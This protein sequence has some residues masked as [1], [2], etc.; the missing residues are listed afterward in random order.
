MPLSH[1]DVP[2]KIGGAQ[3]IYDA[4]IAA[5]MTDRVFLIIIT[6]RPDESGALPVIEKMV[7]EGPDRREE[8]NKRKWVDYLVKPDTAS[9]RE[10]DYLPPESL[11]AFWICDLIA[12]IPER[13]SLKKQFRWTINEIGAVHPTML[14]TIVDARRVAKRVRERQ[15]V[16][17]NG[18]EGTEKA[19]IAREIHAFSGRRH[20]ESVPCTTNTLTPDSIAVQ[21][22]GAVGG[23]KNAPITDRGLF[24]RN[25]KGT[26][27]FDEFGFD[28]DITAELSKHLQ[29]FLKTFRYRPQGSTA[30]RHYKFEGPEV[31]DFLKSLV[32]HIRRPLLVVWDHASP[33]SRASLRSQRLPPCREF[34]IPRGPRRTT[35]HVPTRLIH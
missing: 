6:S 14:A 13:R 26:V 29:G 1:S 7:W 35:S 3:R 33:Q 31:I 28:E 17:I 27:F 16:V 22:F 32:R 20:F 19:L 4:L 11:L 18:E 2:Q 30:A 23:Y 9:Y 24:G 21:L 15:V 25:P 34:G 5:K 12:R 10:A 8:E